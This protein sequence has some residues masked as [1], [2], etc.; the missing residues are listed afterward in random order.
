[1]IFHPLE[2]KPTC[3]LSIIWNP[4]FRWVI[5]FELR[6]FVQTSHSFIVTTVYSW[7]F[8]VF[9]GLI[10]KHE[11]WVLKPLYCRGVVIWTSILKMFSLGNPRECSASK[12]TRYT[13]C[14]RNEPRNVMW[15][16]SPQTR[17]ADS[18]TTIFR[19]TD[20]VYKL[21][22]KNSRGEAVAVMIGINY[23]ENII[24]LL[25]K[26]SLVA[27]TGSDNTFFSVAHELC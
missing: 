20:E 14:V 15:P 23:R 16:L 21:K 22:M 11:N 19:K 25:P 12:I 27:M 26:S 8:R 24:F 18:R 1:M 6:M 7:L 9:R 2:S 4:H 3:N 10:Q 17:Q 5:I 13:V